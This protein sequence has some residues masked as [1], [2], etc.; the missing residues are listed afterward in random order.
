[1]GGVEGQ[2]LVSVVMPAYNCAAYIA[3][4]ID[5]VLRQT[6]ENWELLIVDDGSEDGTAEVVGRYTDPRIRYSRNP[7][8]S[9]AAVSRNN[10]IAAAG[11]EYIAFL[12]SDDVWLPEKL[13]RQIAFMRQNGI[14]F[15]CA[16]YEKMDE[17]GKRTGR[18]CV[19]PKKVGYTGCLLYGNSIGN[20]T[21]VYDCKKLGR[22]YAPDIKKRNDF[23][24]WLKVL[25]LEERCFGMRDVLA[26]YRVRAGSISSDKRS[27]FRYQWELYRKVEGLSAVVCC[28]AMATLLL[29]K[30][31]DALIRR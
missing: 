27:L 15:C 30:T 20:S 31:A 8:N 10:G 11:G 22:V 26:C 28:I 5:S 9:G 23:A 1:M 21:A 14:A 24:L 29:R 17:A 2:P 7:E 25:R 12:D 4:A 19:P 18:K 3:E 16:A 6:Y 13:E